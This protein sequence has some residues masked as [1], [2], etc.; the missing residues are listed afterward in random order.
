MLSSDP[1]TPLSLCSYAPLVSC[2]PFYFQKQFLSGI[3]F[4]KFSSRIK[5]SWWI[6]ISPNTSIKSDNTP[7]SHGYNFNLMSV[8]YEISHDRSYGIASAIMCLCCWLFGQNVLQEWRHWKIDD[9][10]NW[11]FRSVCLYG[12]CIILKKIVSKAVRSITHG[13][14][15][16][17]FQSHFERFINCLNSLLLWCVIFY[18]NILQ[19][20]CFKLY[21]FY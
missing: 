4:L 17:S 5:N 20:H 3:S 2:L 6:S 7:P 8:F 9:V 15:S 14:K 12:F 19:V 21:H 13:S 18:H 11:T 16:F 1:I 10:L